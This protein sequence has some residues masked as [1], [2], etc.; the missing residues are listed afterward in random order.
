MRRE[1]AWMV[2]GAAMLLLAGC[3]SVPRSFHPASPIPPD[4]VSHALFDDVLRSAVQDGAV[5]YPALKRDRRLAE[6]LAQLGRIDPVG[7]PTRQD[8]L[9]FWINAYNAFAIQ[10]ILDGYSPGTLAG[11]YRYFIGRDYRVGGER[12]NLY[13][14]ERSLLIPD[15]RE[16]RV[17]FALVCASRSCPKLRAEAYTASRLE[18]QLNEGARTFINDPARN[19]FD[20][21]R[22]VA[23][24][25]MIFQW[26]EED[27]AAEAGS[28]QRYV[29]RYV[30]DPDLAREIITVPYAIEF[31]GYD[32]RLNGPPPPEDNV[33]GRP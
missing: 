12:I 9:A 7:L 30:A 5:D 11:R 28:L 22:K 8:R 16:P 6:Y 25:S 19:R 24:L 26:F 15:F 27:F 32:W 31:L 14:L 29:A 23:V 4:E 1:V 2:T 20:R 10:G 18:E 3:G 13:D 21:E 17:H 33:A